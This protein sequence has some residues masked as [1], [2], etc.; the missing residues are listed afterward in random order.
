MALIF[1]IITIITMMLSLTFFPKIKLGKFTFNTHWIIISI[2]AILML[3]FGLVDGETFIE[4][5]FSDASMNP[6]K[7]IVLFISM[8]IISIFL[9]EVGFFKWLA[10]KLIDQVKGSQIKI[11]IALYALT[12]FL[13][14]V[15]S[16]DVIILTLTPL[17]IYFTKNVKI[18][19]LPYLFG[20]LVAANTWSLILVIGNPT[21][22]Y[23]ATMQGIEF[24]AYLKVMWLPGL[25]AGISGFIL[26]YLCFRKQ[27]KT[28]MEPVVGAVILKHPALMVIGLVHLGL[29]IIL[30]SVSNLIALEM[31]LITFIIS[32]SLTIIGFIYL[33]VHK[34]S[35]SPM[36]KTY[37][38]A[39]W[40]FIPMILGMFVLV[41]ALSDQGITTQLAS[42][43]YPLDPIW[44]YGL[45]S[46]FASN[47][48]NNQPMSMLFA[49]I[50]AN[51]GSMDMIKATYASIIGSNTGV[52]LTPFGALAGLMWFEL[53]KSY[54][55]DLS[56]GKYIKTVFII[57]FVVL[58]LTL[59]TL[60]I[61]I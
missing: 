23:L 53:L 14:I 25:V 2:G 50:I 21:N 46:H 20:I 19:P 3:I 60:T 9:D 15:T 37:E 22:I 42:W 35:L 43:L 6:L 31:W 56:I 58:G 28:P 4:L 17:M 48:M 55:V 1:F 40:S 29:C 18:N 34:E 52:L 8:T 47:V 30:L 13:T 61:I 16:N 36:I 45:S 59:W 27:L 57:G 7:L 39:P 11:Y 41:R 33:K 10:Y 54:G 12:A 26:T 38:R 32:I 51:Q 44:S 24:F 5:L 49:E